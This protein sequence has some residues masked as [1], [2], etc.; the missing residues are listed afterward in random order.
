M[1]THTDNTPS[2]FQS[3]RPTA[4]FLL[5]LFLFLFGLKCSVL[6]WDEF[7]GKVAVMY[8]YTLYT[9]YYTARTHI[10]L[11]KKEAMQN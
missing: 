3:N 4:T 5:F 2:P 7:N 8:I 11:K 10:M 1:R 6:K 9:L